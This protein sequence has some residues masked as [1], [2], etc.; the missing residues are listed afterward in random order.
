MEPQPTAGAKGK[1]A[2]RGECCITSN[3]F[4]LISEGLTIPSA[5]SPMLTLFRLLNLTSFH[6]NVFY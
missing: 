2:D 1:G 5:S 6:L 4:A 3:V